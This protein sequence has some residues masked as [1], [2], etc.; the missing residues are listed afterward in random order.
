MKQ[1]IITFIFPI[2]WFA[3]V[4][5]NDPII[6]GNQYYLQGKIINEVALTPHCG[7]IAWGT[8]V[9]LEIQQFSDS[10]YHRKKIGVIFTCPEFYKNNFFQVGKTYDIKVAD[11]NPASFDWAIPNKKL[12]DKYNLKFNL[13]VIDAKK[14]E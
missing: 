4:A 2:L 6:K 5:Q 13:W 7:T 9:E 10:S 12:L 11:K 14:I 3:A 1:I 8:I